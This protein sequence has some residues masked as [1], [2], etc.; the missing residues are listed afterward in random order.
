MLFGMIGRTTSANDLKDSLDMSAVRTRQIASRIA[1]AT[2]NGG[3]GFSLPVD[4]QTGQPIAGAD[5][6]GVEGDMAALAE[7]QVRYAATAK[8]LEK[9]YE[10]L[11][12][13]VTAK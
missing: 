2:V 6:T 8:L 10:G 9:T 7:E 5:E 3:N 11:R 4:P 12:S 1:Q 13:S